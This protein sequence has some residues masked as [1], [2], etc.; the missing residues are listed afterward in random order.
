MEVNKVVYGGEPLIDLTEDTVTEN[1]L[2]EGET[3]HDKSGA[4]ITGKAVVG[5]GKLT[6]KNNGTTVGEFTANQTTDAIIDVGTNEYEKVISRGE[7]LVVNGNGLMGNNTNFKALSFDGAVTNN[8]AGSFTYPSGKNATI[9]TDEFFPVNP[10]NKYRLCVDAKTANGTSRAYSFLSFFD[11]DKNQINVKTHIHNS[12]STTTLARELKAGDTVV[13]LTDASGWSTSYSYGFYLTIWNYTNSYGY[14][15]PAGTYSRNQLTLPSVNNKLDPSA[16]NTSAKT[17]TLKSAYTGATVPA[18]TYVSQGG[19]GGT[20]K[21][22][23]LSSTIV[24]TTW[25]TYTG[26]IGGVDTSGGNVAGKFPPAVAYC[27]VGF[28]WNQNKAADQ[29]WVTNVTVDDVS[30]VD[31]AKSYTDQKVAGLAKVFT[32]VFNDTTYTE[33]VEAST[34]GYVV[35]SYYEGLYFPLIGIDNSAAVFLV[36]T[37]EAS[38]ALYCPSE[39]SWFAETMPY[40]GYDEFESHKDNDERH[41]TVAEKQKLATVA[42]T[43][44]VDQK[45]AG[46]VDSSPEALNTLNE[47]AAA[48]GDDPNFATTVANDIGKKV[49]KTTTVNGHALSGNVTVSKGDVGL[50]N[51]VNTGDSASPE[52]GGTKKFTTGGAYTELNKKVDKVPNKGLST[53]DY[54]NTEKNKITIAQEGDNDVATINARY[55]KLNDGNFLVTEDGVKDEVESVAALKSEGIFYIEGTGSTV[56]QWFGA[57]TRFTEPYDGLAIR[58]KIPVAGSTTTTL[59][60]NNKGEVTVYRFNDTKLTTHFEA[61][62]IINL[63][64]HANYQGEGTPRWMCSDYDSNT[65]TY[66][67]VY[68]RTNTTSNQ[69]NYGK[70]FPILVSNTE[71]SKIGT[72]GSNNTYAAVYGVMFDDTTKTPTV[73]PMTGEVKAVKYSGEINDTSNTYAKKSELPSVTQMDNWD[74]AADNA[75]AALSKAS[76]AL[77]KSGGTMTS[78]AAIKWPLVKNNR[79]PFM[80]YCTASSDGSFVIMSLDGTVWNTGLAI[81]GTSGNLLW[82]GAQVAVKTDI[83]SVPSVGNGTLTIKRNGAS[84]GTFSAN[85]SS[86]ASVNISVPTMLTDLSESSDARHVT[87]SDANN[88]NAASAF[89]E[90]SKAMFAGAYR[91]NKQGTYVV[92]VDDVSDIP[93]DVNISVTNYSPG[94]NIGTITVANNEFDSS[95]AMPGDGSTVEV[96][97]NRVRVTGNSAIIC[98]KKADFAGSYTLSFNYSYTG[99]V[100]GSRIHEIFVYCDESLKIADPMSTGAN[101]FTITGVKAGSNIRIQVYAAVNGTVANYVGTLDNITF[102]TGA[103]TYPNFV[104]GS[105]VPAVSP[106][107]VV[108]GSATWNN[109][110]VSYNADINKNFQKITKAILALGGSV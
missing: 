74:S 61:G 10:R 104:N 69:T 51:V 3:A 38:M 85:Q 59:N 26:Y 87:D 73:N 63:I 34:K 68:R 19:D 55:A 79:N 36:S 9:L 91:K 89:V 16:L 60:I 57:S 95:E 102:T 99:T 30:D 92:T 24:P 44:Y 83:P 20:Y 33:V 32:A 103:K 11:V 53:N 64:Y 31:E 6:V 22:I 78:A 48:L 49:D 65:N 23:A 56:G 41:F 1:T 27:K 70:D 52:S 40:V 15:Y 90:E 45:V 67:R 107:M 46:I 39:G 76:A 98:Q 75:S 94:A 72:P 13:Y 82:K 105:A 101:T 18:G 71:A 8:S 109:V 12:A 28:L 62:M 77:P 54:T 7:Q 86:A 88:W 4:K 29:M 97:G 66:L 100:T 21:Y 58:Y 42:S 84:V 80:G 37:P 17:V 2:L 43:S 110:S 5:N 93:H 108:T 81:G 50:G 47:L 35:Q 25:Q 96:D 14:T 106:N